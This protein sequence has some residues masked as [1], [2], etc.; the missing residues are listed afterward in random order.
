MALVYYMFY[1]MLIYLCTSDEK[2]IKTQQKLLQNKRKKTA[3]V[4]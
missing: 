2:Q 4:C 3:M 1:H